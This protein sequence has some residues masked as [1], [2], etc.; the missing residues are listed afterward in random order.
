LDCGSPL[1]LCV[2]DDV[3]EKAAEDCRSPKRWRAVRPFQVVATAT[4]FLKML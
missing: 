3:G 2:A 4:E 1:P